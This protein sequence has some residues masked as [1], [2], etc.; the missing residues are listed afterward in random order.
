[1]QKL[2]KNKRRRGLFQIEEIE[3]AHCQGIGSGD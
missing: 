1:M 2:K 3:N